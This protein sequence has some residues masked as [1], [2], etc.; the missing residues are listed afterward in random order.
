MNAMDLIRLIRLQ[1]SKV[2][3]QGSTTVTISSLESL[4]SEAERHLAT[5]AVIDPNVVLEH[6]KLQH[7]SDLAEYSAKTNAN[8]EL[9]KSVI[10]TSKVAIKSLLLING[11]SAVALLTFI[12][13]LAT[14]GKP[15]LIAPF[16]LPL[17]WFVIGVG[18]AAL[19]AGFLCLAQ[20]AYA[21]GWV[22]SAHTCA[23]ITIL[24]AVGSFVAF[25]FG[26]YFGYKVFVAM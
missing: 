7:A 22:C 20:K 14:V 13:H 8:I 6:A 15:G 10:A 23:L 1:A 5:S 2:K 12:G 24:F 26:S 17:I 4:L 3:G 16:A 18:T 25:G 21:E 11:G 19:F 9:F